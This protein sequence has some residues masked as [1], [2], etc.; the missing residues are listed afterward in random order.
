MMQTFRLVSRNLTVSLSPVFLLWQ[1]I[2]PLLFVFIAGFAFSTIIP[3][4]SVGGVTF[5]YHVFLATGMIG[6]N[7]GLTYN[8]TFCINLE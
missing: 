6:Y 4:L 8:S 2:F 5:D 7:M 3:A 1:I